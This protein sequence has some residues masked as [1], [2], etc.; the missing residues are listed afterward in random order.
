MTATAI[1]AEEISTVDALVKAINEGRPGDTVRIAAGRFE[2]NAPLAPKQKMTIEG[3]GPGKTILTAADSWNPGVAGLPDSEN[4]AAYLF[5]FHKTGGVTI[6]GM[7]LTGPKLHGAIYC[8]GCE[9]LELFNLRVESFLWSGVRTYR[10]SGFKVHDNEFVDAGGKVKH[11]GG[12]LYMHYSTDSEF[13]NNRITKTDGRSNNFFGFKGRKGTRCRFHHNTVDVNFSLEFPFENDSE[14]E[15][16]HNAFAGV[17]SIPKYAGGAVVEEG[18]SFHI[19]HNRITKSYAL[20]WARNGA[21][22]DHNLFDFS[23][24]DDGGNLISEF[25]RVVSP[26]P[27]DFHDNLIKNPGRGVFWSKGTYDNFRFYNNHVIACTPT[28][29]DGLFGFPPGTDFETIVIR[30]N[31]IEC[32]KENPR[33]LMRNEAS[34][35]AVI[36]NNQLVNVSDAESYVNRQTGAKRGPTEPLKFACGVNGEVLVDGWKAT[37]Q[38]GSAAGRTAGDE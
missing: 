4:P 31:I 2:L 32:A 34:Y 36:E 15:I 27:T 16:D 17:V 22:V 37:P 20:E 6:S 23:T 33:P 24:N 8:D 13:W 9:D 5:S 28:R 25:G 12:A 1:A 35:K 10:M 7:T 29:Q 38:P 11:T 26:G 21:E 14:V 19:H 3:A 18:G 30:D